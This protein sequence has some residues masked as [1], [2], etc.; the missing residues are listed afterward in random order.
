MCVFEPKTRPIGSVLLSSGSEA[1]SSILI[2]KPYSTCGVG[3]AA[4]SGS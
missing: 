1:L 2:L 3:Y 4:G